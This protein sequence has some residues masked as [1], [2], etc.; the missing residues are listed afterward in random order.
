M[1]I[2]HFLISLFLVC[3]NPAA[4]SQRLGVYLSAGAGANFN[5][6]RMIPENTFE[7]AYSTPITFSP[8]LGLRF[9]Y[10]LE[11]HIQLRSGILF[12]QRRLTLVYPS[13]FILSQPTLDA[14]SQI[15]KRVYSKS[16]VHVPL[17]LSFTKGLFFIG[18]GSGFI[19]RV[20]DRQN[21]EEALWDI[22]LEASIG[23]ERKRF[24]IQ[25][26]YLRGMR[27][28]FKALEVENGSRTKS[29]YYYNSLLTV[30]VSTRINN[31]GNRCEG[32]RNTR[33]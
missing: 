22:P 23:L 19:F 15:N 28:V 12:T 17:Q 18:V 27:P 5:H 30:S 32:C 29:L 2:Q 7:L 1:K 16:W 3:L 6:W 8:V 20:L 21:F 10:S 9:R 33:L 13:D 11:P 26:D 14:V 25:L 31:P 4:H 24:M